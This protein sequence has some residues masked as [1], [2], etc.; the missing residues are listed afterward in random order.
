MNRQPQTLLTPV[1]VFFVCALFSSPGYSFQNKWRIKNRLQTGFEHDSN[2]RESVEDSANTLSDTSLRLL[3]ESRATRFGPKNQF[4]LTYRGGLQ[5][6][7]EHNIENKLI[8]ELQGRAAF[9][10]AKFV[11]GAQ[12]NG[13]LKLYLN[14]I[15]DY[16]S[17]GASAFTQFPAVL[18]VQPRLTF[19][20]R[21]VHYQNFSAFDYSEIYLSWAASKKLGKRT[22]FTA[23]LTAARTDYDRFALTFDEVNSTFLFDRERQRDHAY[24]AKLQLN[25]SKRYLLNLS[26]AFQ[27]NT[28]NSFGYGYNRH[29]L[30]VVFGV[31]LP[32]QVWLRG[33]GA[34]QIKHYRDENL[35]VFPTDIDTE[36]EES[37]FFIID[38]SKDLTPSLSALTRFAYYDNE[39]I[40]RGRFYSKSLLTLGLDFR[41]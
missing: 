8:N 23:T 16:S 36:R 39:S 17:G 30:T 11:V 21:N 41:F 12:V 5:A 34:L 37:N 28:S 27:H 1:F 19:G 2:I 33:Y 32:R 35:P 13:K 31:P 22:A 20:L 3:F 40:I 4:K 10:V 26:Y 6:Y 29:Q 14:D 18:N 9:K 25:Y 38:V 7:S 15:L 24:A